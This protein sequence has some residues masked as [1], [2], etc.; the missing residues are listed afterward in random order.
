VCVCVRVRVCVCRRVHVETPIIC[1]AVH[2]NFHFKHICRKL[3]NFRSKLLRVTSY[4]M[5]YLSW[6]RVPQAHWH[7]MLYILDKSAS[8]EQLNRVNFF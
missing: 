6:P 5:A 4:P 8:I 3:I 1:L 2:N 7:V